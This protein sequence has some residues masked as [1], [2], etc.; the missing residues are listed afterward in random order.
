MLW[1]WMKKNISHHEHKYKNYWYV[2]TN[3]FIKAVFFF[4][5]E[6]NLP[7]NDSSGLLAKDTKEKII[8]FQNNLQWLYKKTNQ[9]IL[10]KYIS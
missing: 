2:L 8:K 6:S 7:K 10:I 5:L 9:S 4:R 1:I 3:R